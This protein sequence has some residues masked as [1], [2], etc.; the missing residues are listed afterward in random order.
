MKYN[1]GSDA[2]LSVAYENQEQ[3]TTRDIVTWIQMSQ[4]AHSGYADYDKGLRRE[5]NY[6]VAPLTGQLIVSGTVKSPLEYTE[7]PRVVISAVDDPGR[8]SPE[9]FETFQIS[10]RNITGDNGRSF[11]N[12]WETPTKFGDATFA[13]HLPAIPSVVSSVNAKY[14]KT[15]PYILLPTDNLIFGFQVPYSLDGFNE[16]TSNLPIFNGIGPQLTASASG[17]HKVVIY[18]SLLRDNHEYHDTFTQA[19]ETDI[20]STVQRG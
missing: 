7:G 1:S 13:S 3:A 6:D 9:Y 10:G 8:N 18:G 11:I 4:A 17:I 12:P 5:Y 19:I 16:R 15:N 20:V 2:G 14:G